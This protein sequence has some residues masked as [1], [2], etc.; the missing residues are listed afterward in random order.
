MIFFR[1]NKYVYCFVFVRIILNFDQPRNNYIAR[2]II[3]RK[4]SLMRLVPAM[5]ID[6]ATR[7]RAD[8]D[9]FCF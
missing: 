1:I 2:C 4:R 7:W 5:K 3:F 9:I 8:I 6:F